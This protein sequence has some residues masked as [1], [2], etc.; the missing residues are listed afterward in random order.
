MIR[1]TCSDIRQAVG[2]IKDQYGSYGDQ[3]FADQSNQSLWNLQNLAIVSKGVHGTVKEENI[4]KTSEKFKRM[5]LPRRR[6]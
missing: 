4:Y 6:E 2:W 3:R 1:R 5:T